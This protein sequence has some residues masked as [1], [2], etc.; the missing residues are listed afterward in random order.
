MGEKQTHRSRLET[1]ILEKPG[2][3]IASKTSGEEALEYLQTHPQDILV[4]DLEMPGGIDGLETFEK[5]CSINPRQKGIIASGRIDAGTADDILAQ[6]V[7]A[8]IRKPMTIKSLAR[9]VRKVLDKR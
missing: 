9:T 6:G 7:D 1:L 8:C 5:A 3:Q 4:I 2:Y